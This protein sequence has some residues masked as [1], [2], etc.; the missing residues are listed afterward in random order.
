MGWS[1][2]ESRPRDSS[3]DFSSTD[4]A[5]SENLLC[6]REPSK[7]ASS[8]LV[9]LLCNQNCFPKSFTSIRTG[10]K[11][12]SKQMASILPGKLKKNK[13]VSTIVNSQGIN[14]LVKKNHEPRD[15]VQS[16]SKSAKAYRKRTQKAALESKQLAESLRGQVVPPTGVREYFKKL[17]MRQLAIAGFANELSLISITVLLSSHA[18]PS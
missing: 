5:R 6:V 15:G 10:W 12:V 9:S 16:I 14:P 1:R 8:C 3:N 17:T 2:G 7:T 18:E 11:A 13:E 4:K